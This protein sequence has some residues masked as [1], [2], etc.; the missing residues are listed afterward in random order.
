MTN[1][2]PHWKSLGGWSGESQI[3]PK[4]YMPVLPIK[5]IFFFPDELLFPDIAALLFPRVSVALARG[6]LESL[7]NRIFLT[8]DPIFESSYLL[9][10]L[11][12]RVSVA[13]ASVT[14]SRRRAHRATKEEWQRGGHPTHSLDPPDCWPQFHFSALK[15]SMKIGAKWKCCHFWTIGIW[16]N[17][18]H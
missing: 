14:R 18:G 3:F 6:E 1:K 16:G 11:L 2:S 9:F 10:P 12:W 4:L 17:E 13:S 5:Y 7:W 8:N 15:Q